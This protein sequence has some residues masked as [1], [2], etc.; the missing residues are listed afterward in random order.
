[1]VTVHKIRQADA[2]AIDQV[3]SIQIVDPTT[4]HP[5]QHPLQTDIYYEMASKYT[6]HVL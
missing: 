1:M 3:L 5:R 6:N 2:K 4:A